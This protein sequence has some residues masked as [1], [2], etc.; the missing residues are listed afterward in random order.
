[1]KK[2]IFQTM[3]L[4]GALMA[5]CSDNIYDAPVHEN[6]TKSFVELFGPV[7][8][9]QDWNMA[10]LKS[11]TV[12][13]GTG[14][15]I[16]VYARE[17]IAYKLVAHY[18]NVSE[19]MEVKFDAAKN[20][21]DFMVDVNGEI[22]EAKNGDFVDFSG[23]ISRTYKPGSSTNI[24]FEVSND[25][26]VFDINEI[27]PFIGELPERQSLIDEQAANRKQN[28]H[29][30]FFA[31]SR[32]TDDQ[33]PE[34]IVIYPVYWNAGFK[35]ELGIYIK[36][37]NGNIVEEIPFWRNKAYT[38]TATSDKPAV[39]MSLS[40]TYKISDKVTLEKDTWINPTSYWKGGSSDAK[41]SIK[42]EDKTDLLINKIR[43][44]GITVNIPK[45]VTYGFY[46]NVFYSGYKDTPDF[47]YYSEGQFNKRPDNGQPEEMGGHAAYFQTTVQDAN[48]NSYT[49]T[50]MGF[51]DLNFHE[52]TQ[53]GEE[54]PDEDFNDMMFILSPAPYIITQTESSWIVAAE[55]LGTED[56]Y[57]FNDM[58]ISVKNKSYN[59]DTKKSTVE[60][61]GL[62]AGG[63]LPIYLMYGDQIVGEKEFHE[64][65]WNRKATDGVYPMINT[66][67]AGSMGEKYEI[68]VDGFFSLASYLSNNMGGFKLSVKNKNTEVITPP[69]VG[70]A[71]QM[72]CV[73]P[74][75]AWPTE[76]TY[77]HDAYPGF[78]SA[79]GDKSKWGDQY[80]DGTWINNYNKDLVLRNSN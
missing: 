71:P 19:K 59:V 50:F 14:T 6:Y 16:K 55:D 49:Q 20:V 62:A 44:K 65:F 18:T 53:G 57:D 26:R 2:F 48:G 24:T 27:F 4:G 10:E 11:I 35:H 17:G 45:G 33:Q 7:H 25:W 51:E 32:A 36:D 30:D 52:L 9:D 70:E 78:T 21:T 76:R 28:I 58:V 67:T 75:W 47:K 60:V 79:V 72:I 34:Q 63:T 54:D 38:G 43:S 46:I 29:R 56:D 68:K 39:Q 31:K 1:M 74:E 64:A 23:A 77:I 80:T 5:S 61:Q 3:L 69:S 15:E 73:K 8:P 66:R 40:E 37:V 12:D 42:S 22:K 13:P 41:I